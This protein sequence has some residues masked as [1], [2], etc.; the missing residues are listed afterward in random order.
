[1]IDESDGDDDESNEDFSLNIAGHEEEKRKREGETSDLLGD[2]DDEG[3]ESSDDAEES[4][5]SGDSVESPDNGENSII[6]EE[7]GVNPDPGDDEAEPV[8]L[9]VQLAEDGEIE[10]WDI[11][12]VTVTDKFLDRLDGA[13]LRTSGRALFYASVLL[14]MKSDAMLADDD[15][16]DVEPEDPWDD[17]GPGADA[18]RPDDGE[19]PDFDP[20]EQLEDEMERR[21]DRKSAR[22]SPETLDE[23]VREL[24]ERE[25]GSWWKESRSYDTTDSPS[26]FQRGTQ[27][28]DYRTDDDMR[29][30]EEP[31]ADDVTGTAHAEDIEA[32]IDDVREELRDHYEKGRSEVLYAEI[33]SIGGSRIQTFL[34][35]LFLSHRGTVTLEQD[36]MFGDLWVEDAET[37]EESETPAIAD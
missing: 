12:I 20:V 22:G 32:V 33:D 37:A 15:Q 31:S 35:L 36:D 3:S 30:E 21:L 9:L 14:R 23:L 1:M 24:R 25:R 16:E 2:E 4:E 27:T 8:E 5:S 7:L 19:F 18:P 10:P 34:A 6:S 28:L 29:V 11:D 26:G 17:W 13:D